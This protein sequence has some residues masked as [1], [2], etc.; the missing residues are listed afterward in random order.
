MAARPARNRPVVKTRIAPRSGTANRCGRMVIVKYSTGFHSPLF[1]VEQT[2][3]TGGNLAIDSSHRD[4]IIPAVRAPREKFGHLPTAKAG[5]T[6][7]PNP[8]C[9]SPNTNGCTNIVPAVLSP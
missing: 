6:P 9:R 3:I 2:S 1:A 4:A 5:W 8:M 7:A